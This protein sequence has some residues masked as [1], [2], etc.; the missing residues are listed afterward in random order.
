MLDS[1]TVR[2]KEND[3]FYIHCT[4]YHTHIITYIYAL[5]PDVTKLAQS[6]KKSYY[7]NLTLQSL[8]HSTP[9]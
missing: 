2:M 1:N 7:S 9:I 3:K 4:M 5:N 8:K 6:K